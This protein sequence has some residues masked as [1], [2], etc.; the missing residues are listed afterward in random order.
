M[1]QTRLVCQPLNSREDAKLC[2]N[3]QKPITASAVKY[4]RR[5]RV[6]LGE[7]HPRNQGV[8]L[9]ISSLQRAV[10][11]QNRTVRSQTEGETQSC[12]A[13]GGL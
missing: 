13:K 4:S 10:K 5:L 2:T 6:F 12:G 8:F 1:R 3:A 9:P 7:F 11:A